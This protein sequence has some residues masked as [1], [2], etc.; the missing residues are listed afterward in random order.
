MDAQQ[1]QG[2]TI[3]TQRIVQAPNGAKLYIDSDSVIQIDGA[4]FFA[5]STWDKHLRKWLT[6]KVYWSTKLSKL[7]NEVQG[8]HRQTLYERA[9]GS[10][11]G[12]DYQKAVDTSDPDKTDY[13]RRKARKRVRLVE[14]ECVEA[15]LP[16]FEDNDGSTHRSVE[17]TMSATRDHP[18]LV[19]LDLDVLCWLFDRFQSMSGDDEGGEQHDE[20][21]P[22]LDVPKVDATNAYYHRTRE[23]Y[24]V[25]KAAA[26]PVQKT[27][28]KFFNAPTTDPVALQ[29]AAAQAATFAAGA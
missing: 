5:L 23:V 21:E 10:A 14:T 24:M 7:V 4:D 12:C 19:K 27:L 22:S 9:T 18:C 8:I 15:V 26:S 6:G 17:A 16:E 2:W 20:A 28:W 25:K 3:A 29:E 1:L 13:Q 11:F